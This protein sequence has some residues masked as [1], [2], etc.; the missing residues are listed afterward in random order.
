[1]SDEEGISKAELFRGC[2]SGFQCDTVSCE[3]LTDSNS[4]DFSLLFF[5]SSSMIL[6]KLEK[7]F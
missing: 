3:Q 1:M 7:K 5:L 2:W 6:I 4:L